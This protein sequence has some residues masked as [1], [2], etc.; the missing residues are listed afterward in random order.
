MSHP[1][2]VRHALGSYPVY[3][4]PGAL[5]RLEDMVNEHLPGRRVVTIADARVHQL[6]RTGRLGAE[7][8]ES[9]TLTFEPGERSKTREAWGRL[10]DE[11]VERGLGRDCGLIALGGGVTGDLAGFVAATYMRGVPYLQVP[12][13]LLAMLDA[14][15]GGKTGVNTPRGK[16]LVGAFHP[17]AAVIAD[18]RTLHTLQER[19]YRGGLSE[20]V[21]HG[22]IAD[23]AYF[24]WI[25][26]NAAAL[27]RRDPA[28]LSYLIRRSVEIKGVVVADDE[29]ESGRRAILNAGHTV[30]HALEQ[31]S[32]YELLHGEAVAL[33]LIV[34]SQLAEELGVAAPGLRSRVIR[35]LT[36]LGLPT[37]P[38]FTVQPEALIGTM[39]TDKKNREGRIHFALVARVGEIYRANGWTTPVPVATVQAVLKVLCEGK[40][41]L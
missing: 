14:S 10:T 26:A 19:E 15:V 16:N 25:E 8:W 22:L 17:P 34:E 6:Y 11:M 27:T 3:I 31:V 37:Q 28:T 13:T 38:P 23:E 36:S 41:S 39:A 12:T 33:G 7:P 9:E 4:E 35:L 5:V 29:R 24:A 20:A 30:A 40:P 2:V 1:V 21:K 18:P 32:G